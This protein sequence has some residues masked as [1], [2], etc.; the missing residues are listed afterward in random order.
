MER[1]RE[2]DEDDRKGEGSPPD[3]LS[4][5]QRMSKV[6]SDWARLTL[7]QAQVAEAIS[8]REEAWQ[9]HKRVSRT[10]VASYEA[11]ITRAGQTWTSRQWV[12]IS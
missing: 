11:P 6:E 2:N 7:R 5:T 8:W 1:R 3:V 10:P 12:Q 4:T 9:T